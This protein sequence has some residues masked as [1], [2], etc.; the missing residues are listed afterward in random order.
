[1]VV[2]QSRMSQKLS[3]NIITRKLGLTEKQDVSIQ[4]EQPLFPDVP[5][6]N[7]KEYESS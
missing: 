3:A 1:M 4:T 7:G 6:D 5:E 2:E